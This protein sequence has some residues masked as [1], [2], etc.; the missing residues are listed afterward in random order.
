MPT[1]GYISKPF[2]Y[3]HILGLFY[4]ED[5]Y[6]LHFQAETDIAHPHVTQLNVYFVYMFSQILNTC[7]TGSNF[8]NKPVV[9]GSVNKS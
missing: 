8:K 3:S 7:R 9:E 1:R 4:S 5:K 6:N 2:P